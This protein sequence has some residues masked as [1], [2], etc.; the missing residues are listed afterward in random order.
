LIEAKK[1]KGFEIIFNIYNK[2][3]L[4]K[5]FFKIHLLN[6]ELF[7]NRNKEL[8]SVIFA[9]HS[10]WWDG[11]IAYYLSYHLWKCDA[12]MMMDLKQM[13]KYRFFKWI[14]AFSVNKE[15]NT[16]SVKSLN[17][18]IDLI[19]DNSKV[20]WIFPQGEMKHHD[21]RP[22]NFQKGIMKILEKSGQ[23]NLFALV[24]NYEFLMQ[25]RPEVFIKIMPID[26]LNGNNPT[27]LSDLKN[28]L[29]DNLDK[30]KSDIINVRFD[31]YKEILKGKNSRN[32]IIDK[33][34]DNNN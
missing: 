15:S 11:L 32:Q 30:Q 21:L 6:N 1:N 33:L 10:N 4:K 34:Y 17:Y 3:L 23:V 12:Y 27:D 5:N 22:I 24:F 26:Y 31:N 9:N 14:G 8:P 25:Q 2:Y 18:S 19:K 13:K 16:D 7:L 29:T 20:L 28:I